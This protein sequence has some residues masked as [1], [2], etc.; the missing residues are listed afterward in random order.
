MTNLITNDFG[1]R[2]A[3]KF[4]FGHTVMYLVYSLFYYVDYLCAAV[5][6]ISC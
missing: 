5:L 1:N 2:R 6:G 3:Q 4:A